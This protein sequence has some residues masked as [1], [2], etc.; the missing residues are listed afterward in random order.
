MRKM[1]FAPGTPPADAARA[2]AKDLH[3]RW[4]VGD[5]ACNNGV[6]LLLAVDDRQVYVSTGTG[7]RAGWGDLCACGG[8]VGAVGAC[9]WTPSIGKH[10][11]A[12]SPPSL[13]THSTST[14]ARK[15]L[16]DGKIEDIVGDIRPLL[17]R[18]VRC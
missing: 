1:D 13:P 14:G 15:V 9:G 6:L 3:A 5:A 4:G 7:E 18:Q 2:F 8:E 10:L 12:L 11:T 16:P 17:R